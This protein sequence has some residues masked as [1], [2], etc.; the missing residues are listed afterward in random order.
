[1]R[2]LTV[3]N[4]PY[5]NTSSSVVHADLLKFLKD[6]EHDISAAVWHHV[7]SYYM[8]DENE[9][10]WFED[11]EERICE[12][13]ILPAETSKVAVLYEHMK[14]FQPDVVISIGDY[15]EI[16]FIHAIKRMYPHLFKWLGILT[17]SSFP[18]KQTYKESLDY[19]DYV[20][21]TSEGGLES[22]RSLTDVPCECQHFYPQR[23]ILGSGE[24]SDCFNVVACLKNSQQSNLGIFLIVAAG[25]G[26]NNSNIKFYVHTNVDDDGDYDLDYM[27]DGFP[28]NLVFPDKFVSFYD[29]IPQKELMQKFAEADVFVDCSMTAATG[30]SAFEAMSQACIPLLS[31]TGAHIDLMNSI[32]LSEHTS[33]YPYFKLE[34]I[35]FLGEREGILNIVSQ[36]ELYNKIIKAYKLWKESPLLC[37]KLKNNCQKRAKGLMSN[38]LVIEVEKMVRKVAAEGKLTLAVDSLKNKKDLAVVS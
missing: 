8:F 30:L 35:E 3:G 34:A 12:L 2:I 9:Q 20:F 26:E 21:C 25:I 29:G 13:T 31:D 33:F 19:L 38:K 1:V 36:T 16:D 23:E 14:V 17:V 15:H 18:I 37:M 22:L 32:S 5:N 4:S 27:K 7:S 24:L 10:Y 6:S 28:E 11:G